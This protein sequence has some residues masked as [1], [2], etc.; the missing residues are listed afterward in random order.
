LG[1]RVRAAISS[2]Y[3]SIGGCTC[4]AP[5]GAYVARWQGPWV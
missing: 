2:C 4:A 5:V 1:A 3:R